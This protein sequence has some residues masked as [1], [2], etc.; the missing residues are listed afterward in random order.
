VAV[1]AAR[2]GWSALEAPYEVGRCRVLK[3][4]I[5]AELGGTEAAA[6]EFD[7]ARAGFLE[8]GA[9]SGLAELS[10]VTGERSPGTLTDREVEV[11]RLVSTGLTNR[12]IAGRLSLSEKT[13][14]RH[15]SNIFGKLGLSSRSAATAYAYEN[16]LL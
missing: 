6:A 5:L 16:G 9:R 12:A 2:S 14:A 15:L 4:R 7:A 3:G 10:T 1:E 8:L 13:V 11:L